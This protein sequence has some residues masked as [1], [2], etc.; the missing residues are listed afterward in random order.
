MKQMNKFLDATCTFQ[1]QVIELRMIVFDLGKWPKRKWISQQFWCRWWLTLAELGTLYAMWMWM[2]L[3]L[4]LRDVES[5]TAI[6]CQLHAPIQWQLIELLSISFRS[7]CDVE[8]TVMLWMYATYRDRWLCWCLHERRIA[9]QSLESHLISMHS[10]RPSIVL[11]CVWERKR[12]RASCVKEMIFS[13]IQ[14]S[15]G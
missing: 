10:W 11:V 6:V 8:L 12:D 14:T 15:C 13:G 5:R 7:V 2:Y 1:S 9:R 4:M 3:T